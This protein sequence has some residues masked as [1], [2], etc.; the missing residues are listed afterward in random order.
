VREKGKGVEEEDDGVRKRV[1]QIRG[2]GKR[3]MGGGGGGSSSSSSS[4][5]SSNESETP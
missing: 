1:G 3:V 2:G 4:V 5:S